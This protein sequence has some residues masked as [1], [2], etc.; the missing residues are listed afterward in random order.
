MFN[1]NQVVYQIQGT[2]SQLRCKVKARLRD[3]DGMEEQRNYRYGH[4]RSSQFH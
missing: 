2:V 4:R 3:K 1:Q